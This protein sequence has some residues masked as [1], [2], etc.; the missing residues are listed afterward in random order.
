MRDIKEIKIKLEYERK[1][2]KQYAGCTEST[3]GFIRFQI[4]ENIVNVLRWV[5]Q[6]T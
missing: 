3:D 4:A 5:L 1:I 2:L 6:E